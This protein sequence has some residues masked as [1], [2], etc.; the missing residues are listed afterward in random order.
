MQYYIPE[1]ESHVLEF[2]AAGFHLHTPPTPTTPPE[3][4]A[5][6]SI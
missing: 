1:E 3:R 2:A 6:Y 4:A 5:M